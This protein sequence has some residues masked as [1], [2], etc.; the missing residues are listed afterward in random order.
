[1]RTGWK[2]KFILMVN[3]PEYIGHQRLNHIL[4]QAGRI[5]GLGDFRPS[6]GRFNVNRFE[7]LDD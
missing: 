7:L 1:M 4:Q 6:F 2:A 3:L 5:G